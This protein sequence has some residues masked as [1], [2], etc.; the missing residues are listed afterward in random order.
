MFV[1]PCGMSHPLLRFSALQVSLKTGA[2]VGFQFKTH[3]NI[4][5]ALYSSEQKLGVRDPARP[6]PVNVP[7]GVLK[8]RFQTTDEAQVRLVA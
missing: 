8:W 1:S 2:N 7:Q 6:F 4:D 3:P 5:K